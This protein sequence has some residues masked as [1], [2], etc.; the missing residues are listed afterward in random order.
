MVIVALARIDSGRGPE[1]HDRPE[2]TRSE[3]GPDRRPDR[4]DGHVGRVDAAREARDEFVPECVAIG[5]RREENRQ[6]LERAG[7]EQLQDAL[8]RLPR[9]RTRSAVSTMP[10]LTVMI[11]F[12]DSS[13]PMA[14]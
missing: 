9:V 2:A 4:L 13:V 5:R 12:T 3:V 8:A 10:S 6:A 1:E 14:A 11:G 7:R